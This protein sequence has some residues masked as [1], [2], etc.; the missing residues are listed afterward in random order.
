MDNQEGPPMWYMELCSMSCGSLDGRG[1]WR[2][3]DTCICMA[4]SLHCS[5]ETI[6]I[7]LIGYT[8]KTNNYGLWVI[9]LCQCG[10]TS[11]DKC[12]TLMRAIENGETVSGGRVYAGNIY[13]SLQFCYESK[14]AL[15][16]CLL[17]KEKIRNEYGLP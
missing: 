12:T 1:I 2:R 14:T 4:E 7:L 5:P 9:M 15:K 13:T 3:M 11:C 17:I 6:I 16:N 8:P 10:F